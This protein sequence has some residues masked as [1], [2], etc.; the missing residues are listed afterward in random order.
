VVEGALVGDRRDP[1]RDPADVIPKW[2]ASGW[3]GLPQTVSTLL[4]IATLVVVLETRSRIFGW[5]RRDGDGTEVPEPRER[6][7]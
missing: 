1:S 7:G 3:R 5:N 4:W 6:A 2:A